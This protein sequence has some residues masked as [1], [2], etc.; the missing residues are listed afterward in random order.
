MKVKII[1]GRLTAEAE[2]AEDMKA[3]LAYAGTVTA[4]AT[5]PR[6]V[7]GKV[8]RRYKVA[9][10]TCGKRVRFIE[11]HIQRNHSTSAPVNV[12]ITRHLDD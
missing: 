6:R 5:A 3:L 1:A 10:P 9:C 12:P 2:S 8:T 7:H 11:K 4:T